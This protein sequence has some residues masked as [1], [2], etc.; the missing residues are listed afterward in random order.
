MKSQ[1]ERVPVGTVNFPTLGRVYYVT[2][3]NYNQP[4]DV[5]KRE[6]AA[7]LEARFAKANQVDSIDVYRVK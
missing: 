3:T 4:K 7:K 1:Y 2:D 6:P 5:L